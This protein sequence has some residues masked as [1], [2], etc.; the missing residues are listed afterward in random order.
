M[1][2]V[3]QCF[4]IVLTGILLVFF[5][6]SCAPRGETKSLQ[7]ILKESRGRYEKS[8]ASADT[9]EET[10]KSLQSLVHEMEKSF[11]AGEPGE[12]RKAAK[13]IS[14]ALDGLLLQAGY[15]TRPAMTQVID[16]Y[17]KLAQQ[18]AASKE[19]PAAAKLLIARTSRL[20]RKA[21]S[22]AR[23]FFLAEQSQE[24]SRAE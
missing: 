17:R 13:K 21:S 10:R 22:T 12:R 5:A 16:Q 24:G 18:K 8:L 14:E 4:R 6:S 23:V 11:A 15:T 2:P 9:S 19:L 20:A 3:P 7:E 1:R